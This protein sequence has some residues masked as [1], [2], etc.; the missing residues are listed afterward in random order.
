MKMRIL[1]V[2]AALRRGGSQGQIGRRSGDS[3]P[4]IGS[5]ANPQTAIFICGG[6]L[7]KVI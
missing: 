5:H 4:T 6:E 2:A 3:G 7:E 1:R